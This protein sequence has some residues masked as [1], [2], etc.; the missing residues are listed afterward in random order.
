MWWYNFLM[1]I[2]SF[3][4]NTWLVYSFLFTNINFYQYDEMFKLPD[5]L[6]SLCI[7]NAK[8]TF[9][10][11]A[12][13]STRRHDYIMIMQLLI[14]ILITCYL[15]TSRW[16]EW[17]LPEVFWQDFHFNHFLFLYAICKKSCIEGTICISQLSYSSMQ[18]FCKVKVFGTDILLNV[19]LYREKVFGTDI[20][21]YVNL[22]RGKVFGI[23]IFF[24]TDVFLYVYL[25]RAKVFGTDIF[26]YVN[27]Y[28]ANAFGTDICLGQTSVWKKELFSKTFLFLHLFGCKQFYLVLHD[29]RI[30]KTC[31]VLKSDHGKWVK[32]LSKQTNRITWILI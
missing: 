4:W 22:Y 21:L 9:S 3:C 26:L 12:F 24:G 17:V 27:L 25:H 31:L 13:T 29:P 30:P 16:T 6:L 28:R 32:K 20:L 14:F 15:R 18:D 23:D 2:C 11:L 1:P 8:G 10:F 5:D 7:W 19:N